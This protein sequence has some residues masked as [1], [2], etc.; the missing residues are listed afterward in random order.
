MQL[1]QITDTFKQHHLQTHCIAYAVH[2]Y[3]TSN[4]QLVTYWV[5]TELAQ[6]RSWLL[7]LHTLQNVLNN[8]TLQFCADQHEAA[9]A[10][11]EKQAKCQW[12]QQTAAFSDYHALEGDCLPSLKSYRQAWEHEWCFLCLPTS[13]I[14]SM[15]MSWHVLAVSMATAQKLWVLVAAPGSVALLAKWYSA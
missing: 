6:L 5:L 7:I 2:H 12:L 13:C 11:I 10:N 1:F 3:Q 4:D 15:A 14:S 9:G 8:I